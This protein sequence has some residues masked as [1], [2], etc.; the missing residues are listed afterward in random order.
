MIG[1]L[2]GKLIH[3]DQNGLATVLVGGVGYR[4]VMKSSE[5]LTGSPL[6]TEHDLWIHTHVK[7]DAISLYG[8]E[9]P[10][11]RDCFELLIQTHGIG[12]SLALSILSVLNVDELTQAVL[13]RDLAQ[14]TAVPGVGKKT[15]ERLVIELESKLTPESI[16]NI[17][18]LEGSSSSSVQVREALAGLGFSHD[19]IKTALGMISLDAPVPEIIKEAL[20]HLRRAG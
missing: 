6:G 16:S 12:P 10:D 15:A 3:L 13:G 17:S 19:E 9:R 20:R 11:E 4:V 18:V 14:L 8:F 1:Y 7:E 5:A 2:S